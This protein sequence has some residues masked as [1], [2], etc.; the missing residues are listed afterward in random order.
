MSYTN[1]LKDKLS[2]NDPALGCFQKFSDAAAVELIALSGFDF[3][4][5]DNEH[6]QSNP[7]TILNHVRVARNMGMHAVVRLERNARTQALKAL[8]MGASGI[9]APNIDTVEDAERL[10]S[11]ARFAPEGVRGFGNTTRAGLYG[12]L[13]VKE[14]MRRGN[15]ETLISAHCETRRGVENIEKIARVPGID[16]I[17]IGPGDLSQAYGCAGEAQSLELSLAIGH[18]IKASLAAGKNVG[19]ACQASQ[20]KDYFAQGVRFFAVGTD[21]SY[22]LAGAGSVR[23]AFEEGTARS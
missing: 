8:D 11:Y 20:I 13:P 18:I 14:F 15:Q 4:I 16:V 22:A 9:Q 5:V 17:F 3:V 19:I 6:C 12:T 23:E 21:H 2:R 10:V 1:S 7:E